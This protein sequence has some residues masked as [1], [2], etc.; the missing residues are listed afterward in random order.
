MSKRSS[1]ASVYMMLRGDSITD[2][3]IF[4]S[5]SEACMQLCSGP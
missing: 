1:A 2:S 5:S 4:C 3:P